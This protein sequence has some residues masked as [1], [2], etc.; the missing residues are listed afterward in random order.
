MKRI[1]KSD[2]RS[3]ATA[4]RGTAVLMA[5]PFVLVGAFI[6]LG[7]FGFVPLPGKA[8]APLWVIGFAGLAFFLIGSILLIHGVRGVLNQRRMASA[9]MRRLSEPWHADYPWDPRGIR[10]RAGGRLVGTVTFPIFL[11]VFLAPFHWW[12]F[13]SEAG[14]WMVKIIVVFFDLILVLVIGKA[15]Y[16]LGRYFKFGHSRLSFRRFPF[17]PGDRLLVAFSGTPLERLKATLRFVEERFESSG[18]GRN[19]SSQLASYEHFGE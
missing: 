15:I 10:D 6:A 3:Q 7:G 12:A 1:S 5:V 16:L 17:R 9:G 11:V 2:T 14:P 13:M 4:Y 19:R 18:S 8:N